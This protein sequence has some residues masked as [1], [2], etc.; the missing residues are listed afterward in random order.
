[1]AAVDPSRKVVAAIDLA[2]KT[3]DPVKEMVDPAW[4]AEIGMDLARKAATTT[5]LVVAK[6]KKGGDEARSR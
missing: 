3:V 6:M 2:M 1:V 5:D 4:K